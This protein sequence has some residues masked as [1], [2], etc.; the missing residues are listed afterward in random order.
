MKNVKNKKIIFSNPF[1]LAIIRVIL[2]IMLLAIFSCGD[3][4]LNTEKTVSKKN[5]NFELTLKVDP[6]IVYLQSS[7]KV[8]VIVERLK[9]SS[10]T[11]Y[12]LKLDAVGG[13][14]DGN[15]I[16]FSFSL[17]VNISVSIDEAIGSKFESLSFFVPTYS[18]S[19][20]SGYSNYME[21]GHVTAKYD[22]INV[23]LPIQI[24]K[25]RSK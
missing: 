1:R 11:P 21:S 14:L 20:S 8:T 16:A 25:P 5:E 6:D 24:L 15:G 9:E 19:S 22:N 2:S 3:D 23:T 10:T 13:T 18:Y 7:T 12:S 17:G 4:I